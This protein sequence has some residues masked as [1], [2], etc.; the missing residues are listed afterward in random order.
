MEEAMKQQ[1]GENAIPEDVR[2]VIGEIEYKLAPKIIKFKCPTPDE[3][4]EGVKKGGYPGDAQGSI[5]HF[6][7][8]DGLVLNINTNVDGIK[9]GIGNLQVVTIVLNKNKIWCQYQGLP[10]TVAL[11]ISKFD[12]SYDKS[13][14]KVGQYED[15]MVAT[16]RNPDAEITLAPK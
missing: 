12:V 2:N 8:K 13:Q 5:A 11:D 16:T 3:L 4:K 1:L 6:V 9:A 7:N 15:L 14:F 10:Q